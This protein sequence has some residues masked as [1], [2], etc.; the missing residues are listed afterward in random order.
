MC[1]LI[2]FL[3][4]TTI[5]TI[6]GVTSLY[7]GIEIF[8]TVYAYTNPVTIIGALYLLL[9]FSKINIKSSRIINMLAAGSFAVYLIHSQVDIRPLFNKAV[10]YLYASFNN[11]TCILVLFVFLVLVYI[12]SVV[13]D[14]PRLWMWNKLSNRFN[15]K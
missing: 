9:F 15:I 2:V 3:G 1:D 5:N 12:S 7:L 6:L 14:I 13:I 4:C 8:N 10:Q 11:V